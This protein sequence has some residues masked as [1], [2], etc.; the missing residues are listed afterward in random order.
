MEKYAQQ[1]RETK[2]SPF[3]IQ[4][5]DS[6]FVIKS[7]NRFGSNCLQIHA[8]GRPRISLVS[9]FQNIFI[10]GTYML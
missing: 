2:R 5:V 1:I 7:E 3:S 9:N 4:P 8:R 6:D 10:F